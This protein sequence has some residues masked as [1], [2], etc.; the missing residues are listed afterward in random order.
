MSVVQDKT[1]AIFHELYDFSGI[2]SITVSNPSKVSHI[3]P[4]LMSLAFVVIVAGL[5]IILPSFIH[6]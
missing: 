3:I 2:D 4:V 6:H 5:A 1:R